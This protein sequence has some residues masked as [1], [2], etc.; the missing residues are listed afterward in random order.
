LLELVIKSSEGGVREGGAVLPV[1][2]ILFAARF[3]DSAGM[4]MIMT[5]ETQQLP[6]AT[7]WWI[8]VVVVIF[9]VHG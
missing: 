1:G 3:L 9:V 8:V 7:V 2:R 6:V 4:L 5:V